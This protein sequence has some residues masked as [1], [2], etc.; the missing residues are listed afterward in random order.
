MAN[1]ISSGT[2]HA[3]LVTTQTT[4]KPGQH[5]TKL[6]LFNADGTPFSV[7]VAPTFPK[8][9]FQASSTAVD[10]AGVVSDFNALL[11]KLKAAGLMA[12]A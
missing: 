9:A 10:I 11:T 3:V 8:A 7:P 2:E 1:L 6:A 12:S 5:L 4:P